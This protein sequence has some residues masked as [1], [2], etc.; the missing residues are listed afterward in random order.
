VQ[1]YTALIYAGPGLP[2]RL[3]ADLAERL[4]RDGFVS[5]SEAVGSNAT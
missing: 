2:R 5:I 1:L 3:L 4:A